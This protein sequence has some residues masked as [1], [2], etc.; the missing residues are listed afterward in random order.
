[1]GVVVGGWCVGCVVEYGVGLVG[2]VVYFVY[3]IGV[4]VVGGLIG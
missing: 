3:F 2:Y 4:G 1:M